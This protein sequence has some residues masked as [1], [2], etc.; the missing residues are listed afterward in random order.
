MSNE[1][2]TIIKYQDNSITLFSDGN[3]EY[4]NITEL[5]NAWKYRRSILKWMKNRQTLDFLIAWERKNN[6]LFDG[7][8]LGTI[9]NQTKNP[10]FSLSIGYWIEN[11]KAIGMF[12]KQSGT[13]AHKDIAIR[14]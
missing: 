10:N 5:A 9:S 8:H 11:T 13:F 2:N 7:T 6:K 4:I 12:T 1:K 14:W 3:Q